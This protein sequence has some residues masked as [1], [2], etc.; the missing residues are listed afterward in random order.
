MSETNIQP[1]TRRVVITGGPGTGKS[2]LL[3]QLKQGGFSVFEEVSRR[4]I[5]VQSQQPKPALPWTNLPLFA[6]LCLEQMLEQY[7]AAQPQCFNFYDR[8]IPD[9]VAYLRNGGVAVPPKYAQVLQDKPY[10]SL[11]FFA[12]PWQ[13]IYVNDQERPQKYEESLRIANL[14]KETYQQLGYCLITLPKVSC[15]ARV[16]FVREKLVE[17]KWLFPQ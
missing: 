12:P 6:E 8:A 2:T 15:E 5:Q 14:L 13:Q 4:L 10:D 3:E 16:A 9:I 7:S 1:S 11:V 17:L